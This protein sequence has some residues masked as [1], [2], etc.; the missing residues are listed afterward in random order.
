[1][2][3]SVRFSLAPT[4]RRVWKTSGRNFRNEGEGQ[5]S[6]YSD[7][8]ID[9]TENGKKNWFR[10]LAEEQGIIIINSRGRSATSEWWQPTS[11][12]LGCCT[13]RWNI[14]GS[15]WS[16]N[17]WGEKPSWWKND[18]RL[19]PL[20]RNRFTFPSSSSSSS[21]SSSAGRHQPRLRLT[22]TTA[23]HSIHADCLTVS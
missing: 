17:I 18:F 12:F 15:T 20:L 23:S 21:S 1:M 11:D 3:P 9:G 8:S 19:F 7:G 16:G 6:R 5:E 13:G 2:K 22:V 10:S 4:T 14:Q